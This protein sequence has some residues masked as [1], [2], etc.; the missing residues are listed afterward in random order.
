MTMRKNLPT[1]A[2]INEVHGCDT[3]KYVPASLHTLRSLLARI[4]FGSHPLSLFRCL[5]LF[6][7]SR[8]LQARLQ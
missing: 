3:D 5:I 8:R 2:P 4:F 1:P 6:R 7:L